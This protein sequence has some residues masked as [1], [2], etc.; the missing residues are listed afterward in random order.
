MKIHIKIIILFIFSAIFFKIF[1]MDR[2]NSEEI[3]TTETFLND[4]RNQE[5]KH[6]D[7]L[8][9]WNQSQQKWYPHKSIEGGSDTIAYG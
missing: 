7:T 8:G 4:Q 1:F 5:N 6:N 2:N 9:G 3:T